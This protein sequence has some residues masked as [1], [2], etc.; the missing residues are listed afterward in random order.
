MDKYAAFLRGI[1]VGGHVLVPMQE[2]KQSFESLKFENVQTLLASGNIVFE[3]L[4]APTA[5]LEQNIQEMLH[6]RF[7]HR[8]GVHVRKMEEMQRLFR[9]QPFK[10]IKITPQTRL[11]VTFLSE[12]S[13][14]SRKV[15]HMPP[16]SNFR[17]LSV[18]GKEVCSTL[19]LSPNT[20]TVHLMK[21]LEK[22]YGSEVTTRNWNSI[23]RVHNAFQNEQFSPVSR[24][25]PSPMKENH[26]GR[27]KE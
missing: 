18:S 2:L 10:G 9:S 11:Y 15:P 20:R 6:R 23:I 8:I 16:G 25:S 7:G 21:I 1:N 14:S 12:L 4:K 27:P 22:E 26:Y 13:G 19:V 17:I 3:A 24:P 5:A